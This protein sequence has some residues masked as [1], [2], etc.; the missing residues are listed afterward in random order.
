MIAADHNRRLCVAQVLPALEEG[1]VERGTLEVAAA[2]VE[3]GHR[4]LVVSAGGRMV[5]QLEAS[6]AEHVQMPVGAKSPW[7]LRCVPKLRRLLKD[8]RVDIVHP[9]SRLP[10][11]IT[12]LS[13]RR[14]PAKYR[15]RLVTTVHGFYSVNAYSA[16]MTRGE[17][18]I[19][20]SESVR[21]YILDNYQG[22]AD[23]RI[24]VIHRGVDRKRFPYGFTPPNEWLEQFRAGL[25]QLEGRMVVTLPGRLTRWKGQLDFVQVIG[26]LL[27]ANLPV[28]GLIVGGHDRRREPYVEALRKEIDRSDLGPHL[29]LLGHRGDVREILAVS[30]VVVSLS[31]DPE[32]FGRTTIEALSLGRPVCG[33]DHGGVGEQLAAVLPQGAVPVG[34]VEAV[35]ERIASWHRQPPEIPREHPFT[36]ERMLADTLSVYR[37]VSGGQG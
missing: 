14:M 31:T 29:T 3:N 30:D 7:T 20:V 37:E 26:R 4:A 5:E 25:P 18:I 17:R 32:A 23:E 9:R 36:L 8:N 19:A 1:G 6:G 16:V 35:A 10:A 27:R 22:V 33:Y 13:L 11:W 2:L 15:P 34:D 21:R 28:H 12:R 24:R